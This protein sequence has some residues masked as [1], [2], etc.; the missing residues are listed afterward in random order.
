MVLIGTLDTRLGDEHFS[1][2]PSASNNSAFHLLS[3]CSWTN[4]RPL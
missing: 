2:S 3:A 4:W 1:L